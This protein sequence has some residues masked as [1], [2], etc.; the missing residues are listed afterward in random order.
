[1]SE[2]NANSALRSVLEDIHA[3]MADALLARVKKAQEEGGEPLTASEITAIARFLNDS[4]VRA[5][6]A[7]RKAFREAE[8][9]PFTIPDELPSASYSRG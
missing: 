6:E 1:M 2:P 9:L 5:S 8:A 3:K 4:D 7:D